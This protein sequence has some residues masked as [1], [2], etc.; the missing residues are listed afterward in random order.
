[1][2]ECLYNHSQNKRHM[3]LNGKGVKLVVVYMG[4]VMSP[5]FLTGQSNIAVG[6]KYNI[7]VL[8]DVFNSTKVCNE[9]RIYHK[10]IHKSK[11]V[12]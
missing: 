7:F 1:M 5:F 12:E 11:M 10:K 9:C 4:A 2:M 6:F 8:V 3:I